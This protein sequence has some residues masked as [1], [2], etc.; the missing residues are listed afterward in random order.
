M[1]MERTASPEVEVEG[2]LKVERFEKLSHKTKRL[3]R[4]MLLGLSLV[5]ANSETVLALQET[6]SNPEYSAD[7]AI[8]PP[9]FS[10]MLR[11]NPC[12]I[13]LPVV[14]TKEQDELAA[15]LVN[16]VGSNEILAIIQK[17]VEARDQSPKTELSTQILWAI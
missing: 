13:E 6:D 9:R 2:Q 8:T 14:L 15:S 3:L 10:E 12:S 5:S 4:L 7:I 11:R 1:G 16:Q 17:S